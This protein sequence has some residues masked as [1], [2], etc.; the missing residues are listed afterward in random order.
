M[1]VACLQR[2]FAFAVEMQ[3]M[4]KVEDL[5]W[6]RLPKFIHDTMKRVGDKRMFPGVL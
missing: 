6:E 5:T 3:V 1:Q 2:I 4:P